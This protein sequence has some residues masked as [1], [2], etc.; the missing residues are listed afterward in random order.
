M[1]YSHKYNKSHVQCD[2][3]YNTCMIVTIYALGLWCLAYS[4]HIWSNNIHW[5]ILFNVAI[6]TSKTW[7]SCWFLVAHAILASGHKICFH[8]VKRGKRHIRRKRMKKKIKNKVDQYFFK[9]K[10]N[11]NL[12]VSIAFCKV[13]WNEDTSQNAIPTR[14]ARTLTP[15][16]VSMKNKIFV[17]RFLQYLHFSWYFQ[18]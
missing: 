11:K 2:C 13:M 15:F 16:W 18:H 4:I 6:P 14:R 7:N 12:H 9:I 17:G 1:Q 8:N 3:N 5:F 10:K